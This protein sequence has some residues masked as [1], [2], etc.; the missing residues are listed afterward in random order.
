[1]KPVALLTLAAFFF[2]S[3]C[4]GQNANPIAI[5]VEKSLGS[6]TYKNVQ[7]SVRGAVVILTST[8][9][10]Y[11]TR[12]EAEEQVSRI[13]G[14]GAIQNEIRVVTSAIPDDE[15]R[16]RVEESIYRGHGYRP[17]ISHSLFIGAHNGVVSLGGYV[18]SP[19]MG[20]DLLEAVAHTRGV[21]E[22]VNRVQLRSNPGVDS[23]WTSAPPFFGTGVT[24]NGAW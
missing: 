5:A 12:E 17:D 1:M 21:R 6:A 10:L 16:A 11:A 15:L 3:L 8:V 24:S 23:S 7:A 19:Q 18:S 14:I 20:H 13:R 9:D 4:F 2:P 22:I